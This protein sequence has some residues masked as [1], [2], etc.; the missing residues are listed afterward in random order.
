MDHGLDLVRA[1][2]ARESELAEQLGTAWTALKKR[3]VSLL[4]QFESDGASPKARDELDRLVVD[5]MRGPA[6][7][8][9]RRALR[10]TSKSPTPRSPGA[11]S[12]P[13]ASAQPPAAPIK[14]SRRARPAPKAQPPAAPIDDY[15]GFFPAD[16]ARAERVGA[17]AAADQEG[18]VSV[19]VFYGTSRAPTGSHR[20]SEH[21]GVERGPL[22]YGVARVSIPHDHRVG[23]LEK[24]TWWKL[25]FVENP[26]RHV[27]LLSLEALPRAEFSASLS[28]SLA[29]ADERDVLLFVHGYNVSFEDAAR[30]TA[31]LAYDLEFKGRATLFSWP[32]QASVAKYTVDETNVEWSIPHFQQFLTLMLAEVGARHVHVVAHSMGNRALVRALHNFD[33][34]KLPAGSAKLREVIFAAPDIDAETFVDLAAAFHGRASRFTLYASDNDGALAVSKTIHKYARAGDGGSEIVVV[35]GVDTIDASAVDT[36]LLGHSYYGDSRS[37]LADIHALVRGGTAPRRGMKPSGAP[38]R[39]YWMLES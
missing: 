33:T 7:A 10:D 19:P 35:A 39:R 13:A 5:L 20:P 17:Q 36:S 25:E 26:E 27:V 37:I 34:S 3:L 16:A 29:A 15:T 2:L 8:V 38:K 31:Q 32:S 14:R 4:R 30:R 6:G 1:L 23:K 9:A 24:P 12:T 21:F 18:F 11:A 28:K 22:A